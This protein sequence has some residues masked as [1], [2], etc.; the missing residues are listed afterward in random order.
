M[1][2]KI[3][4]GRKKVGPGR[5]LPP[6][7]PEKLIHHVGGGRLQHPEAQS[8]WGISLGLAAV[9][10]QVCACLTQ[11]SPQYFKEGYSPGCEPGA[12]LWLWKG[13]G[14]LKYL[15]LQNVLRSLLFQSQKCLWSCLHGA[16]VRAV[17]CP[18][19]VT[20]IWRLVL[21][22]EHIHYSQ[23][24]SVLCTAHPTLTFPQLY[25]HQKK[26]NNVSAAQ[27]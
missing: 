12:V 22:E 2:A 18:T 4:K 13:F 8:L 11:S 27:L 21:G 25:H 15:S 3:E 20:D 6:H 5:C 14:T 19:W 17:Y 10:T 7:R 24:N 26:H 16:C 9:P 23:F 1:W